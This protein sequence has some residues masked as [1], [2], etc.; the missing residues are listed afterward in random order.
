MKNYARC[1]EGLVT[2]LDEVIERFIALL[3]PFT[4]RNAP[5]AEEKLV[6]KHLK[7]HLDRSSGVGASSF[8]KPKTMKNYA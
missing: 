2:M 5:F 1:D 6:N 4:P 8:F 7:Y 3:S